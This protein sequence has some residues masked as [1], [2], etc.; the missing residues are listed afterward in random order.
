MAPSGR[1]LHYARFARI[2]C[3][4]ELD[5]HFGEAARFFGFA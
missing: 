1:V 4:A 2:A 3:R 5:E